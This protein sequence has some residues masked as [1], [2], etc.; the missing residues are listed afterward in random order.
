M[1]L[2]LVV[3]VGI[4]GGEIVA[5]HGW[6]PRIPSRCRREAQRVYGGETE[7]SVWCVQ[8]EDVSYVAHGQIKYEIGWVVGETRNGIVE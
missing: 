6:D 3:H 5:N 8:E 2:G 4:L 7:K 1:S